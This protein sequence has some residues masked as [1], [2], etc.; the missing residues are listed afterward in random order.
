MGVVA[1]VLC[2]VVAVLRRVERARASSVII[3]GELP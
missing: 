3:S 2:F 1:F